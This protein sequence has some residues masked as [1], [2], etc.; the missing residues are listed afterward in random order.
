MG[1]RIRFTINGV[2]YPAAL[3]DHPLAEKI[4]SLCPFEAEYSRS[5]NHEYYAVLPKKVSPGDCA[6]TMKGKKNGIY[7]FEGWNAL[8]LVI[9]DCN[10]APYP[11]YHVG[12]FEN[13]VSAALEKAGGHIRILCEAE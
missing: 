2:A 12:N 4:A 11:I 9:Q 13:D 7:F 8:S 5:G 6:S 3:A 1:K 10:T